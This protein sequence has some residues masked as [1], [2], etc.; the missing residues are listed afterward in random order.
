MNKCVEAH[1]LYIHMPTFSLFLTF[2]CDVYFL[3]PWFVIDSL[4]FIESI[5]VNFLYSTVSWNLVERYR[6]IFFQKK[7]CFGKWKSFSVLDVRN[8]IWEKDCLIS[9]A[10]CSG[11]YRTMMLDI[12]CMD[13]SINFYNWN[14]CVGVI[15]ISMTAFVYYYLGKE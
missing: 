7:R 4:Y 6:L 12:K 15:F 3:W 1:K 9:Q 11:E 10:L 13:Y 14:N 2:S 8:R 5:L